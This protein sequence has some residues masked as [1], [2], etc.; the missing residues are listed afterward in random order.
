MTRRTVFEEVGGFD[1]RLAYCF[2][3][4]DFCL[5]IRQRGYLIVWT[6]YAELYHHESASGGSL[7]HDAT[8]EG[9]A[10]NARET[11]LMREKWR[12]ML[13]AGDPY[14]S[15]NLTLGRCDFSIRD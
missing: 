11:A 7:G 2:N 15:P 3:D 13:A 14:Y 12:D 10:R 6:P 1:E 9:R 5:K 8:P 4:V